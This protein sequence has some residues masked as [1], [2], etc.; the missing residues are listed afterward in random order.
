[1]KIKSIQY[2]Q[3]DVLIERCKRPTG[4]SK[5]AGKSVILA[6]GEAT[7]HAHVLECDKIISRQDNSDGSFFL[8]FASNAEVTHQ[9][10]NRIALKPGT[11]R[12]SRQREYSP[13]AIRNV[14]D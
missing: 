13:Q 10:H 5:P 8:T 3:G 12:I 9:E 6:H 14:M 11:Y 4:K 1:M 2:R 7:G